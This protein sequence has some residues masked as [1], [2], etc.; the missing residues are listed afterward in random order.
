[1]FVTKRVSGKLVDEAT[2]VKPLQMRW[3]R[4]FSGAN[5][6]WIARTPDTGRIHALSYGERQPCRPATGD[7]HRPAL[8]QRTL[9]SRCSLAKRQLII[10]RI[11]NP[12]SDRSVAVVKAALVEVRNDDRVRRRGGIVIVAGIDSCRRVDRSARRLHYCRRS[13]CWLAGRSREAHPARP[14]VVNRCRQALAKAP[15]ERRL[16]SLIC[17]RTVYSVFADR[18]RLRQPGKFVR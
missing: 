10:R 18:C 7:I 4:N 16:K 8:Y 5:L 3:I 9:H 14:R 12:V 15:D 6:I 1:M 17:V 11:G 2:G 13:L